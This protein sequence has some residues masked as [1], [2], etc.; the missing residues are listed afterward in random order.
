VPTTR[1]IL[2]PLILIVAGLGLV[3]VYVAGQGRGNLPFAP[4]TSGPTLTPTRTPQPISPT[5]TP[6]RFDEA[7]DAPV[8]KTEASSQLGDYDSQGCPLDDCLARFGVSGD[9]LNV[10]AAHAKG[11]PFGVFLNWWV[12]KDPPAPDGISFWQMVRV[13]EDGPVLSWEVIGEMVSAQPNS[14]WIVGNEPDIMWQDNVTAEKYAEIYHDVYTFIKEKDPDAK[15]AIGGVGQPTPL[16]RAY[17]DVVLNTYKSSYQQPMPVD[18]WTVHNFILREEA[19]SWGVGIPPGMEETSGK[20]YEI[21]DHTNLEIFRQNLI[22]FRAWMAERGYGDRPLA[23]TEIGVLHPSD[24]GFPPE[25]VAEFMVGAFD[26]LASVANDTGLP[27]DDGRLV[28]WWFWYSVYDKFD[29]PTGNLYEPEN[30]RLTPL[31]EVFARY[32][33]AN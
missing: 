20:L 27:E 4:A 1:R 21:E 30:G 22:D 12:E 13:S 8:E 9:S 28:Q 24:F 31:G 16:R 18:I 6:G 15:V 33:S 3:I 23:V 5:N 26:I 7:G 17:L 10:A 32:V 2:I 29:F 19:G 25:I 11:L 14:I